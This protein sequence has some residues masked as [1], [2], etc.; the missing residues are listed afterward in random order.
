MKTLTA[1]QAKR[2]FEETEGKC[3]HASG[4]LGDDGTAGMSWV[5]KRCAG[6]SWPLTFIRQAVLGHS[7]AATTE[8][9]YT[10]VASTDLEGFRHVMNSAIAD[11]SRN[12]DTAS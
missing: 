3:F 9:I 5:S 1:Q 7:K 8:D 12:V 4:F 6:N 2:L 10:H 11:L